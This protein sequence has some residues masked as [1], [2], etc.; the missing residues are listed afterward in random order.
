[1]CGIA[2]IM[3]V[4]GEPPS[5][6]QLEALSLALGH[7]GPDGRGAYVNGATGLV[8][9]RLAIID[10]ETGDQPLN[11]P[12]GTVLVA[13]GEIYNYVELRESLADLPFH[14]RSDCE[15]PLHLYAQTSLRFTERLR[16]MYGLALYVPILRRRV[17]ARDPFGC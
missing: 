2:G 8:H 12:D 15:P 3:T 16:G 1:M 14:T 5:P 7:R 6:D 17:L 9:T 10:L 11:A 4:T 13:N